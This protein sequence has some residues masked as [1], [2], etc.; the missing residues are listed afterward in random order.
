METPSAA[1]VK[2]G[3]GRTGTSQPF[4]LATRRLKQAAER[5]VRRTAGSVAPD[6][7]GAS[8]VEA[9]VDAAADDHAGK[10]MVD[11]HKGG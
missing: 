5:L 2:G 3:N 8:P 9:I 6:H 11:V 1:V 4:S 7:R 10:L